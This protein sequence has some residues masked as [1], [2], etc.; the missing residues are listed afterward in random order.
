MDRQEKKNELAQDTLKLAWNT[1][2][3][4]LRFLDVALSRFDFVPVDGRLRGSRD[5]PA[6][7]S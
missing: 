1:L 7:A 3:V 2:L 6:S 4:N 5:S